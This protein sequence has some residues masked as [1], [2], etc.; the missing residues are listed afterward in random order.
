IIVLIGQF[1]DAITDSGGDRFLIQHP[2]GGEPKAQH[3]VQLSAMAR[4]IVIAVLLLALAGPIAALMKTPN[5]EFG[6]RLLALAP[7][8]NGFV[9]YDLLRVQ[10]DHDFRI[11]G[12][13]ML[14]AEVASLAVTTAAAILT[15]CYIAIVFGLIARALVTTTVSHLLAMR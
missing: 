5:V 13:V 8:L 11:E 12:R 3:L 14:V 2:R 6:L 15:H 4:G 7:L 9:H 10:R 1:F